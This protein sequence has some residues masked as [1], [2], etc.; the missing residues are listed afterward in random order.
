MK[1]ALHYLI[2]LQ[3][4]RGTLFEKTVP[5]S[6]WTREASAKAFTSFLFVIL[7]IVICNF[8]LR[9]EACIMKDFSFFEN[10]TKKN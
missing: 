2:L 7:D 8:L 4:A 3:A 9:G 10:N 1:L 6:V 5:C